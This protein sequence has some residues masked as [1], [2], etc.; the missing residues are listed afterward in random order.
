MGK[1]FERDSVDVN[2]RRDAAIFVATSVA[3]SFQKIDRNQRQSDTVYRFDF[4]DGRR[5]A[6]SYL[7]LNGCSI[8]SL[9]ANNF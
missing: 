6:A 7:Q 4:H 2:Y 5:N 8:L 3:G 1:F 9:I